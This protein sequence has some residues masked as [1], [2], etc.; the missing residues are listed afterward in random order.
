MSTPTIPV[1]A[2][3]A[4]GASGQAV[5]FLQARLGIAVDGSFGPLTQSA[6]M[7]WQDNAG[8]TADGVYGPATNT[9]MTARTAQAVPKAAQTIG[10]EVAALQAIL[11]VETRATGFLA[12]GRPIILLERA[13]V[14]ARAT[15]QQRTVLGSGLADPASGGYIGGAGEWVRFMNV[16]AVLGAELAAQCCSW[17]LGQVMGANFAAAGHP[18]A[19]AM[20]N[21]AALNEDYQVRMVASFIAANATLLKAVQMKNWP[22]VAHLYNGP[23]YQQNAYDY[24]LAAAYTQAQVGTA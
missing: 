11:S 24:K 13:Y 1:A 5:R 18:N 22:V 6:L 14:W 19:L 10:V 2:P 3:L 20:M 12:D 9:A 21:A 23:V 8:L 16:A 7:T 4:L 15:Q 17:G